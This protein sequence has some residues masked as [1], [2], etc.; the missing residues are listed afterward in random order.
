MTITAVIQSLGE[1]LVL[2]SSAV[3]L[4]DVKLIQDRSFKLILQWRHKLNDRTWFPQL[5]GVINAAVGND[6]YQFD[7]QQLFHPLEKP[8]PI[9][10]VKAYIVV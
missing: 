3:P 10:T 7:F 2:F 8:L 6:M 1:A 4:N 9:L 5:H